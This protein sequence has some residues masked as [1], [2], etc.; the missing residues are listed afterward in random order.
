MMM[1]A[2]NDLL[3]IA[4]HRPLTRR[5][6]RT[7]T[8]GNSL[9]QIGNIQHAQKGCITFQARESVDINFLLLV[10][11]CMPLKYCCISF[12]QCFVLLWYLF[13]DVI[14]LHSKCC[15]CSKKWSYDQ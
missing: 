6:P 2:A 14:I 1:P 12:L 8:K 5:I 7:E 9:S 15:T 10:V 11:N 13:L 3:C 4:V